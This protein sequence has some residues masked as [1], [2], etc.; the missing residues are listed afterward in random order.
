MRQ[1]TL[2]PSST[3]CED[4]SHLLPGFNLTHTIH[5][6]SRLNL[7]IVSTAAAVLEGETASVDRW[8]VTRCGDILEQRIVL[9]EMTERQAVRL[10]EQLAA[11]DGV[12]RARME[13]HFVRER[14]AASENALDGRR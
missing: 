11:L 10:R 13:H 14:S 12:L 3:V 5:L 9:G 6:V 8:A 1:D 7:G 4:W 2:A